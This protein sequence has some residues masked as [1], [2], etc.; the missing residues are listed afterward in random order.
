MTLT[1]IR[2]VATIMVTALTL[3][4]AATA[5]VVELLM[6]G[7]FG[8]TA[9]IGAAG[10]ATVVTGFLTTRSSAGFRYLLV[11]VL[12]VSISAIIAATKGTPWQTDLHMAFFASLALSSLLYDARVILVG[13]IVIAIHHLLLGMTLPDL[14]F[15]GGGGFPRIVLHAVILLV[16]AAGL[17][18]L[19][20]NTFAFVSLADQNANDANANAERAISLARDV[21]ESEETRVEDRQRTLQELRDQFGTVITATLNGEFGRRVPET[22]AEPDLNNLAHAVND[23]IANLETGLAETSSVMAA[24]SQKDLSA[25]VTGTYAPV[26]SGLKTDT[27]LVAD[28]MSD[29]ITTIRTA[30]TT[31]AHATGELLDGAEALARR[32]NE[33]S[34]AVRETAVALE[35]LSRNVDETAER[36]SKARAATESVATTADRGTTVM[37]NATAAMERIAASSQQ[38]AGII[39]M[40]DDIAFQTN[41]LALNASV[42]AARAGDAGRGFAVVAVEVR[43]LAQSAASS[44]AQIKTLIEQAT[45]QVGQGTVLVKEAASALSEITQAAHVSDRLM[46]DIAEATSEQNHA[47]RA[48][49]EA[50]QHIDVLTQH[51]AQLVETT[52]SAVAEAQGEAGALNTLVGEFQLETRVPLAKSA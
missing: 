4:M 48:I 29:V 27:N 14:V 2:S 16:E 5:I 42:E 45:S 50:V 12:M 36:A 46:H 37:T 30:T 49:D 9:L 3:F 18:W 13:T 39:T 1:N 23:L 24:L 19:L 41:L 31:L 11:T 6:Q 34:E 44:S 26:F 21:E 22:F 10:I 15:Y 43:R 25:R 32:T 51:N 52:H 35:Q 40:I 7:N 38:I 20:R 17:I 8:T 33:Q 47:L 28:R